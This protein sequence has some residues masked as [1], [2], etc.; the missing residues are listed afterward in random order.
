MNRLVASAAVGVGAFVVVAGAFAGG[1][2]LSHREPVR[3]SQR[4]ERGDGW[5]ER[6]MKRLVV[7]AFAGAGMLLL[8]ACGGSSSPTATAASL[9][10]KAGAASSASGYT[11]TQRRQ[12]RRIPR[13]LLVLRKLTALPGRTR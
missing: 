9:L 5:G 13:A 10:S 3:S 1:Y 8:A 11:V 12:T 7:L 6:A 2:A 4:Y